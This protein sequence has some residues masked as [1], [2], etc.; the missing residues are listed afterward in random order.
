MIWKE[1]QEVYME[2]FEL[3]KGKVK[4]CSYIII[5]KKLKNES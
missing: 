2:W 3:R 4:Y 5:F 1:N